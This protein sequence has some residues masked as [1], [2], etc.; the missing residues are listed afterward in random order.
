ME[1]K[2]SEAGG[3]GRATRGG[4]N[5]ELCIRTSHNKLRLPVSIDS[6]QGTRFLSVMLTKT[7]LHKIETIFEK[8]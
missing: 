8:R 6:C 1:E 4:A 3:G 5:E 7:T 2:F